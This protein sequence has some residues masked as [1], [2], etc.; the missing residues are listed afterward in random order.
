MIHIATNLTELI[1]NT[2]LLELTNLEQKYQLSATL[3]G[4]LEYLNPLGSVKDRVAAA[5]IDDGISQGKIDADTVIVEPTS[6]NT[7]I[8][9]AMVAA[10]KG[11]RLILTMPDTMSIE[12]RKIVKA[13]GAEIVLTPGAEGMEGSIRKAAALKETYGNAF[14]PQQF[15]NPVN[16]EIHFRTTAEEI[17]HDTEGKIDVLISSIG[18]GGTISGIGKGLKIHNPAI[19]IIGVEPLASAVLHGEQPGFHEIQGIGAG[20]IPKVLDLNI[21]DEVLDVTNEAAFNRAREVAKTDGLLI[22]ISSG[23]SID[24][25]ITL[26]RRPDFKKKNIVMLLPDGGERYIST[27]LFQ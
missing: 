13:L 8:G 22:G 21:V 19:Q 23:A 4:K 26:A 6:G 2:P 9:L 11:L 15:D 10:V 1:G 5:M 16:P 20:F 27:K 14:I 17:W 3:I 7:G 18:T 25:A 12:R 24:A